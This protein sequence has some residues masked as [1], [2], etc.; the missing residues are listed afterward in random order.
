MSVC[1]FDY[2]N[3]GARGPLRREYVDRRRR[4][5]LDAGGLSERRARRSPRALPQ[6]RHGQSLFRAE[7]RATRSGFEDAPVPPELAWAAGRGRATAWDFDHDGF[8]D[9]YVANGMVSRPLAR[10]PEQLLLAAGG[11]EFARRGQAIARV[12]TGMERDQRTDPR[13]WHLERLR[14]QCLLRQQSGRNVFRY[15]GRRSAS[16]FS[17]TAAPSRSPT[18]ITTAGRKCF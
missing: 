10:R 3:D 5:H 14:A 17:K 16:T 13:R 6:A 18:S 4:A 8:P 11:R 9:L 15:F 7:R 1:W 12:R 2:D